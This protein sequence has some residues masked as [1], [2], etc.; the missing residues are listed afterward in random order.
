MKK[1]TQKEKL[2]LEHEREVARLQKLIVSSSSIL[3]NNLRRLN[4]YWESLTFEER[5]PLLK[6]LPPGFEFDEKSFWFDG[7][8]EIEEIKA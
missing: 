2:Q 3:I 4:N 1:L 7:D 5:V 6:Q 8:K